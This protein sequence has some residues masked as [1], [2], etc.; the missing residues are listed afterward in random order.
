VQASTR[1]MNEDNS[2]Y[3]YYY[4]TKGW[5]FDSYTRIADEV[6]Y[7]KSVTKVEQ[8][9]V[10]KVTCKLLNYKTLGVNEIKAMVTYINREQP[11]WDIMEIVLPLLMTIIR[12]T[13]QA[14]Q[15][16]RNIQFTQAYNTINTLREAKPSAVPQSLWDA[17]FDHQLIRYMSYHIRESFGL[18]QNF[19]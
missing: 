2:Y 9:L 18:V 6:C 5:I 14:E 15:F 1:I 16:I 7:L 11:E 8:S 12:N 13:A 10:N 4:K 3:I 19:H 17:I